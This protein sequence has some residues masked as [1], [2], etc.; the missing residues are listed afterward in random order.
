[1]RLFGLINIFCLNPGV[2]TEEEEG[3]WLLLTIQQ[4]LVIIFVFVIVTWTMS[5]SAVKK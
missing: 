5:I 3:K 4:S 2:Q 1:M